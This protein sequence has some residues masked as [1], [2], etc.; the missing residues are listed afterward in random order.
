MGMKIPIP[1]DSLEST[2]KWLDRAQMA[3]TSCTEFMAVAN[4]FAK[5]HMWGRAPQSC[6]IEG[7]ELERENG[8]FLF[9]DP[10]DD[11]C[12]VQPY[13]TSTNTKLPS[14]APNRKGESKVVYG[15]TVFEID[16]GIPIYTAM[17]TELGIG[18]EPPRAFII[19]AAQS[20]ESV[21]CFFRTRWVAPREPDGD[22]EPIYLI[23]TRGSRY[24]EEMAFLFQGDPEEWAKVH[25]RGKRKVD[26]QLDD[27]Y[28]VAPA[29]L[30][31]VRDPRDLPDLSSAL[32]RDGVLYGG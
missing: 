32:R 18:Q 19:R 13:S 25:R 3:Q 14:A 5:R 31:E 28:E 6:L 7:S 10:V 12:R 4:T 8:W 15:R 11:G 16:P 9:D 21:A 1:T 23:V 29:L 17:L 22:N 30:S 20:P 24:F 27:L 2:G 26:E